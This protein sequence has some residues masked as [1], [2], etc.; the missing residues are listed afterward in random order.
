L[1]V[2]SLSQCTA[3]PLIRVYYM[4]H[5]KNN[6]LQKAQNILE[7]GLSSSGS[8]VHE[9]LQ[10]MFALVQDH[11]Q[12]ENLYEEIFDHLPLG[13]R[14]QNPDN[15]VRKINKQY[16]EI[17]N[18]T[19]ENA[20]GKSCGHFI[21]PRFCENDRCAAEIIKEQK[22]GIQ[23]N[24]TSFT[25]DGQQ[26]H[27][28]Y[29][30]IPL[31]NADGEVKD[32]CETYQ[33]ISDLVYF[34]SELEESESFYFQILSSISD[35]VFVTDEKFNFTFV[36]PNANTI[37]RKSRFEIEKAGHLYKIL[38]NLDEIANKLEGKTEYPNYEHT[39]LDAMGIP[40]DLLIGFK[41]VKIGK[42][43]WLVTCRDITE[44]KSTE[45][46]LAESERRFRSFM[47]QSADGFI[48][49]DH[50][51][52]IIEWNKAQEEI[53]GFKREE[54][55]GKNIWEVRALNALDNA[56][57]QKR[58]RENIN[59]IEQVREGKH[60][61]SEEIIE[62][63]IKTRNGCL[64]DIQFTVF[65]I[66]TDAGYYIGSTVRDITSQKEASNKLRESEE[67]YRSLVSAM[68]EGVVLH[69]STGKVTTFN[70]SALDILGLSADELSGKKSADPMWQCIYPDG[71]PFPGSD[72]PVMVTLA[73]GQPVYN[74]NMGVNKPNGERSWI[75]INSEP[76]LDEENQVTSV[77]VTFANI[78]ENIRNLD[79]LRK[80]EEKFK[81]Y[82]EASPIA[83]LIIDNNGQLNFSNQSACNMLLYSKQELLQ[84]NYMDI[85]P[86]KF[87]RTVEEDFADLVEQDKI[88]LEYQLVRQDRKILD[89]FIEAVKIPDQNMFVAYIKDITHE[90]AM[91]YELEVYHQELE[92]L[93]QIRTH[94]VQES[95]K[96][97][98]RAFEVANEGMWEWDLL[99]NYV[100]FSPT[101][102][103]MLG[104]QPY[105]FE[106]S[107]HE[108]EN[109]LHPDHHDRV[110]STITKHVQE[111]K[112]HFVTEFLFLTK[113]GS[114]KWIRAK[115]MA[116]EQDAE[117]KPSRFVGT[118]LDIHDE[119]LMYMVLQ[120][121]EEKFRNIFN[122]TLDSIFIINTEGQ[123]LDLNYASNKLLDKLKVNH[124]TSMSIFQLIPD[125]QRTEFI[126]FLDQVQQKGE[127]SV[128]LISNSE[129]KIFIDISGKRIQYEKQEALI[130]VAR[131][132]SERKKLEEK[133]FHTVI[134]TEEKE[135]QRFAKDLHDGLGPQ[136]SA[137]KLYINTI[138]SDM[139]TLH[140]KELMI[141]N[142]R[143][144]IN[145]AID[146][147]KEIA[148]DIMPSILGN[149]GF[150]N[151]LKNFCNDIN[152]LNV[153]KISVDHEG[154][155]GEMDN[156]TKVTLYRVAT[157]LIN[158]TIKHAS[159]RYV[160]IKVRGKDNKIRL[161]Y[162]DDGEGFDVE[163]A[164]EKN[165]GF[166]LN[167]IV[168]RIKSLNG[169]IT[170]NSEA[171][172]GVVIKIM[173]N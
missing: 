145:K 142:V 135:R 89:V 147:T 158:N 98:R 64:K 24:F 81:K 71:K 11:C 1:L 170:F 72:H 23:E 118:H 100:F 28:L 116:V 165:S 99:S 104:Y 115:A 120:E 70:Q 125:E 121:N 76:I 62:D 60:I 16:A 162:A 138:T 110:V 93:V 13:I 91:Q 127:G 35:A 132:I 157:E 40:H 163:K 8:D 45:V 12:K 164:M 41:R 112:M 74:V 117:G 124:E 84:L 86:G 101:Y 17:T 20:V 80:S 31:Y 50:E 27:Y 67:K 141:N 109:R 108:W 18:H 61:W 94:E 42:G 143:D 151:A 129:S 128:E 43:R 14:L 59:F 7:K 126:I 97:L 82:I 79:L 6:I 39:V 103:T 107:Y 105:E 47:D 148:N 166:G 156:R 26:R 10:D 58:L 90:K 55:M 3:C 134:E 154:Y 44:H 95:E 133:L 75:N 96:R 161:V 22:K 123:V 173:I 38:G 69:D 119:K 140:Q 102:Y 106:Q 15:T 167:N 113:S 54:V 56:D 111:K 152:K 144:I 52:N 153:V 122:S 33:D 57:Y 92:D 88:G 131:D 160:F 2:N 149:F 146:S 46:R 25:V 51:M 85:L 87:Y 5:T 155:E 130:L 29:K 137:I 9:A 37:F 73:S 171:N 169:K 21:C 34:Q 159:A 68:A 19:P 65:P 136:L 30:A 49:V 114:Y 53:T 48:L 172:A 63:C 168:T 4:I 150:V 32:I 83:I 77:V 139:Y 78:T 36:C 66:E